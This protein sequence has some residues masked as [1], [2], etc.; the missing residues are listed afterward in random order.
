MG[1]LRVVGVLCALVLLVWP[2][3]SAAEEEKIKVWWART[4]PSI[5]EISGGKLKIGG[6]ITKD[7]VEYVKE[8]MPDT[9]YL[10]TLDGAVWEVVAFTPGEEMMP[11]AFLK[12]TKENE[13]KARISADGTVRMEDG[14]PWIGGFPVPEATTGLEAMVNRQF[15]FTDGHSD[16]AK[17]HW[18]NSHNEVY[19]NVVLGVRAMTMTGRVSQDPRPHYPGFENQLFRE[20]LF[21]EDPYD[22]KGVQ[23][24]SIVYVDQSAYPDSWLY[25]PTFRRLLRASSG[26][27]YDSIDGS[28]IRAGDID[29]FSDPLGL[30]D[31]ELVDRKFTFSVIVGPTQAGGYLPIAKKPDWIIGEK[32]RY[33][34]GARLELRD[35]FIVD[36]KPK[37]EYIWSKK[38]LYVDATTYW[39]ALGE[40]YDKQGELQEQYSLFWQRD[41]NEYGPF[42]SL[43]WVQ[44]RDYQTNQSTLIQLSYYLRNPPPNV[45][46]LNMFTLKHITTAA[47]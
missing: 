18:V 39:T 41:E 3:V 16:L 44:A 20:I 22:V 28:L 27:R 40:F 7:N 33:I 47:R 17:S 24:L 2:R 11:Q 36:G 23:I 19:K 30:W 42:A 45:S 6:K 15:R 25:I 31:F 32:S 14:S 4:P 1:Q 46:N 9:Y 38:R 10:D 29:S 5:E 43:T 21:L 35:T 34:N 26:Q 13:G 12:A 8:Y 37:G